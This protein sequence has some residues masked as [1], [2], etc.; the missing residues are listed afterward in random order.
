MIFPAFVFYC[1]INGT[2]GILALFSGRL[3]VDDGIAAPLSGFDSVDKYYSASNCLTALEDIRLPTLVVNAQNDPFLSGNSYPSELA[4][5]SEHLF[6]D[7]PKRGG[8]AAFPIT[9]TESW[10]PIR[11]EKFLREVV[12]C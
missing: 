10:M 9:K 8:H 12:I 5:T 11:I 4:K 7:M 3:A 1:R 6:L 2:A